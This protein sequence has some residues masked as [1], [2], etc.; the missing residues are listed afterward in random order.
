MH[1]KLLFGL[2]IYFSSVCLA[3]IFFFWKT[4][5]TYLRKMECFHFL[6][7][8][9]RKRKLKL[10][11]IFSLIF[12]TDPD[13]CDFFSFQPNNVDG[14]LPFFSLQT[15]HYKTH[16]FF[17]TKNFLSTEN[18]FSRFYVQPNTPLATSYLGCNTVNL[19]SCWFNLYLENSCSEWFYFFEQ[20]FLIISWCDSLNVTSY[21]S[22]P[23]WHHLW[24]FT[25]KIAFFV[26]GMRKDVNILIYLDVRKALQGIL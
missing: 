1:R 13:K 19:R 8:F 2:K 21:P 6:L 22:S 7:S 25:T 11:K 5:L 17:S 23:L 15:K 10:R 20:Y 14:K 12:S 26:L 16:N 24:S 18:Y 9:S 3:I 4:T